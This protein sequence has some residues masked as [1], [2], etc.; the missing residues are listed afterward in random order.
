MKNVPKSTIQ[1]ANSPKS[2]RL[3]PPKRVERYSALLKENNLQ[4]LRNFFCV[5]TA[6]FCNLTAPFTAISTATFALKNRDKL[7][8]VSEYQCLPQITGDT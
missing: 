7:K 5:F 3:S 8:S 6:P 1:C 4:F 2:H